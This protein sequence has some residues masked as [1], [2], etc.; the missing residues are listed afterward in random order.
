[1]STLH[2]QR[3]LN[4]NSIG[5]NYRYGRTACDMHTLRL[6]AQ[7]FCP[8]ASAEHWCDRLCVQCVRWHGTTTALLVLAG[9]DWK[10]VQGEAQG[11][12]DALKNFVQQLNKG[13]S[14][15]SVSG[16]EQSDI[17]TK[18]GE[19]DFSVSR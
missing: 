18:Y 19:S 4:T 8:K 15:A 10:Q 14:A 11:S 6:T 13:P 12:A 16:V 7:I 9:T 1:V 2:L 3:M 5:V 17:S